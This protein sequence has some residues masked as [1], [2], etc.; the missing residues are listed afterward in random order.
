MAILITS[1]CSKTPP[2]KI[3]FSIF[4]VT[5]VTTGSIAACWQMKRKKSN[6]FLPWTRKRHKLTGVSG[7]SRRPLG[8]YDPQI[9]GIPFEET[10]QHSRPLGPEPLGI[11]GDRRLWLGDPHLGHDLPGC[12]LDPLLL[13]LVEGG[14]RPV[15]A[16]LLGQREEPLRGGGRLRRRVHEGRR[17]QGREWKRWWETNSSENWD[18]Q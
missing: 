11:F 10:D 2:I 17:E 18:H 16:E 14:R 1:D 6:I 5:Q 3:P 4:D 13:G 9:T 15:K 8:E 12:L 7:Q